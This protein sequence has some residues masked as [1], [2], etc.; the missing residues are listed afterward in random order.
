MF[1]LKVYKVYKVY[2]DIKKP[3]NKKKYQY[4]NRK[5]DNK[6][7]YSGLINIYHDTVNYFS[8]MK[9]PDEDSIK[10]DVDDLIIELDKYQQ[11]NADPVIEFFNQDTLDVAQSLV[12]QDYYP[13]VLN[14]AS[15]FKPGGGVR[16]GKTAQ[17]EV[18]FRR[19]NAFMTHPP[20]W[21]PLE[22]FDVIYS[23]LVYVVKDSDY[24]YLNNNEFAISMLAVP[25]V[26]NPKLVE[27]KYREDDEYIMRK[28]IE[29]IFI[30]GILQG[31]DSLVLGALG[32]GAYNNPP[33]EVA[34]IYKEYLNKYSKYFKK[35][36]FGILSTR[37]NN[38][39]IFKDIIA[40]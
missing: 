7:V 5:I 21:Y 30:I 31:T 36:V 23:P 12:K 9:R 8:S 37:D 15:K 10:Y 35:I 1:C 40:D 32:S 2:M 39:Q 25:A 3:K 18:I 27:G 38:Y 20:E 24:N 19:S 13:M 17:E 14:M 26:R 11:V 16:T 22:Q 34:K 28:K 4:K 6:Y 33:E 29:S